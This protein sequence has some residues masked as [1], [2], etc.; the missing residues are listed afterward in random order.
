MFL[1][2]LLANFIYIRKIGLKNKS[3]SPWHERTYVNESVAL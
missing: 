2:K 3:N 1:S